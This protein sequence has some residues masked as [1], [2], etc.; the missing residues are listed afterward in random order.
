M[1]LEKSC[2]HMPKNELGFTTCTAYKN[3]LKLDL[4]LNVKLKTIKHAEE[5]LTE[6]LLPRLGQRFLTQ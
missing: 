4:N 2:L 6:N 1:V 5:S 3:D